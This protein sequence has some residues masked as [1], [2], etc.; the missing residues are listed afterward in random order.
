MERELS[1]EASGHLY[2]RECCANTWY[3]IGAVHRRKRQLDEAAAAFQQALARVP[4]HPL[5]KLGLGVVP[6]GA[7]AAP[8]GVSAPSFDAAI[9]HVV[10]LVLA[11]DPAAAARLL[12]QALA[13]APSGSAGWLLPVEPTLNVSAAPEIWT[14]ALARLR[15]RAA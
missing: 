1:F 9:G 5:A 2:A 10:Q 7:Q 11:G 15:S 12:D 14:S 13:A 3:A 6:P 4:K 8:S